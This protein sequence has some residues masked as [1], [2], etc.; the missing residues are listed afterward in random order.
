M[1]YYEDLFKITSDITDKS[2]HRHVT[3]DSYYIEY[4]AGGLKEKSRD[5]YTRRKSRKDKK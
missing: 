3:P 4:V 5:R 2:K 1:I